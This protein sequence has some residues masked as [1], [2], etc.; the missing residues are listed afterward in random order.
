MLSAKS[1]KKGDYKPRMKFPANLEKFHQNYGNR[2]KHLKERHTL[3]KKIKDSS[4]DE[5]P[6]AEEKKEGDAQM[7]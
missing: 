2:I 7:E 6:N 1:R 5:E 4:K 3:I